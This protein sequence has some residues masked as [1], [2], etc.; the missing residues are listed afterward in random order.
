MLIVRVLTS[1]LLKSGM[2]Y[3]WTEEI[4]I[5]L[6][7]NVQLLQSKMKNNLPIMMKSDDIGRAVAYAINLPHDVAIN[8]INLS[9]IGWPEM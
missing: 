4:L 3:N 9:A 6:N 7:L 1:S 8:E 5:L 2:R